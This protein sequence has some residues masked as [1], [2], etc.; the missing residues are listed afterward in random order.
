MKKLLFITA[1]LTLGVNAFATPITP[2]GTD[3]DTKAEVLVKA[4]IV[5][6]VLK[7]TDIDGNPLVLDFKKVPKKDYKTAGE[8][9]KAYVE[10]KI[11]ATDVITSGPMNLNMSLTS[12]TSPQDN[13]SIDKVTIKNTEVT[14][15][16]DKVDT[17]E[18]QLGLDAKTKVIAD[19]Q[20]EA[21][22]RIDGIIADDLSDNSVGVYTGKVFLFADVQ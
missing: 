17:V 14:T 3:H 20:R 12:F 7:I 9:V 16:T 11:T 8:I 15:V 4:Q 1:L 10:Y 5:D 19:G 6:D 22:G 21:V 18:V 13:T 2:N